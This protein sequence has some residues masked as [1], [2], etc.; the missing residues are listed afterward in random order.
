MSKRAGDIRTARRPA[1]RSRHRRGPL[2][3]RVTRHARSTSTSTS[4]W[5][6]RSRPRTPSTTSST[7]TRGSPRSC[8]RPRTPACPR[9]PTS[10]ACSPASPRRRSSG[11][12]R[13][14]PEVVEDAV[15][16]EETQGITAYATELATQFHA[17]YRDA[18]VVDAGAAGAIG[19]AARA[20][21]GD[22]D[23]ARE[24]ARAARDLRAR[25]DVARRGR[26]QADQ[27]ARPRTFAT[28]PRCRPSSR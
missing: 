2:V 15:A 24:R 10:R 19:E 18:R 26:P 25:A 5:P 23:D 9:R 11:R 14:Y 17:F 4:S 1:G 27:P 21:A 8:A 20:G 22:E 28:R 16:A 6:G 13:G 7:P 3:L 12:S